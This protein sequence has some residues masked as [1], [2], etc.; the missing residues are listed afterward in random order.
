MP[1]TERTSL[2]HPGPRVYVT[3][4]QSLHAAGL[5]DY[6]TD[7][8]YEDWTTTATQGG[9]IMPELFG[10]LCYLSFAGGRGHGAYIQNIKHE[11][12]G[13]VLEHATV[14]F[15]LAGVSRTLTHELVRHRAGWAY[16][17]LSQRYVDESHAQIVCPAAVRACRDDPEWSH[18]YHEWVRVASNCRTG[19]RF[20]ANEL[21]HKLGIRDAK[22]KLATFWRKFCRGA[23]RSLM[24]GGTETKIGCTV[25]ARALRH[26]LEMR[27]APSADLEIREIALLIYRSVLPFWPDLLGDYEVRL[28][29]QGDEYLFTEYVK[30]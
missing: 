2:V 15:I 23:A 21:E 28:D 6:L 17:M 1:R 19:Y 27:A 8:G 3:G 9:E 30:V 5:S 10:R 14:S 25:N 7:E 20:V 4:V 29:D 26:F 22:G 18:V 11:R 16:S 24:P 13:S 12:H